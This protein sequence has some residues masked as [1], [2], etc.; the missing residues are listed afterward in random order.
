M[1]FFIRGKQGGKTNFT[2]IEA[3]SIELA[4][5]NRTGGIT[6]FF[7]SRLES[8]PRSGPVVQ[9]GS[10]G[11]T[12]GGSFGI[13]GVQGSLLEPGVGFVV[14]ILP[15]KKSMMFNIEHLLLN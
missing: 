5:R 2:Q 10:G 8:F 13:S 4:V 12:G 14:R 9:N 7:F 1:F 3:G 15:V 11:L 6:D